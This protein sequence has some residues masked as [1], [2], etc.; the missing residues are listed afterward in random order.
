VD[1]VPAIEKHDVFLRTT[2]D[3][4]LIFKERYAACGLVV[5]YD[6][7]YD[8]DHDYDCGVRFRGM[9]GLR[10]VLIKACQAWHVPDGSLRWLPQ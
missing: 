1:L 7:D 9:R 4:A 8:H 10:K 6:Y 5:D 3:L 2:G